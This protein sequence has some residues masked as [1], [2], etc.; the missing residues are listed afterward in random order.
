[1]LEESVTLSLRYGDYKYIQPTKKKASWIKSEK[2][3]ESGTS[4][5]PQLYNLSKDVSELINIAD[6]KK[7]IVRKMQKE[8]RIVML[9]ET[10]NNFL[11]QFLGCFFGALKG[12]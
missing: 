8:L 4:L 9:V 2:N 10:R 5:D 11:W 7:S 6:K 12:K 1:L 3:I